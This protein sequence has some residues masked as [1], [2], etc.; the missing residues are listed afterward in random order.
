MLKG[1][2]DDITDTSLVRVNMS[3]NML[4]HV[5]HS[6]LFAHLAE[7]MPLVCHYPEAAPETLEAELAARYGLAPSEVIATNGATEAIYLIAQAFRGSC[8]GIYMPAFAEYA[9]AARL[10]SHRVVP[11]YA[12]TEH[13]PQ[14]V[15]MMWICNPGNPT[16]SV[17]QKEM[18]Q[19]M[20]EENPKVLF[21]LD[22]SY[23]HF[24]RQP[25]FSAREAA[26]MPNVLLLHSMTKQFRVPG[27]RIGFATGGAAI[28]DQLQRMRM[29][30]SVNQ[31]AI[32]AARYLLRHERDYDFDLDDLI[33]E[34]DRL[35]AKLEQTRVIEVYPS[36]CHILLCRLRFGNASALKDFLLR[37]H[38]I[39]IRHA[40]NFHGLDDT[41]FRIAVQSRE[42]NDMLVD[43]IYDFMA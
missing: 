37:E 33:S 23:E 19:E 12:L 40:G 24:T 7:C 21:V 8:S 13:L 38:G 5:D 28:I 16:G 9:D 2:G 1:H 27:L 14:E 15:E 26:D 18:L 25:L 17:V 39:L 29:P 41:H 4:M 20:I 10:H 43:A 22:Q 32:C 11:L 34:K 31:L 36:Q 6:G 3:S 30:W 42:E 35:A